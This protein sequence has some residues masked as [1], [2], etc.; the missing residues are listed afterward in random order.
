MSR[1]LGKTQRAILDCLKQS[2][3]PLSAKAIIK[4]ICDNPPPT[5][6]FAVSTN[7]ALKTLEAKRLIRSAHSYGGFMYWLPNQRPYGNGTFET[8][9]PK[10]TGQQVCDAIMF[11][12]RN[13]NKLDFFDTFDKAP[14]GAVSYTQFL[15]K[16]F[17]K[18]K[19]DWYGD[20]SRGRVAILRAIKKLQTEEKIVTYV[21]KK[22]GYYAYIGLSVEK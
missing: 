17:H 11:V 8:I 1:G 13:H 12:L 4:N 9:T 10:V 15:D 7:R 3:E 22:N 16:V 19:M 2:D 18:L 14:P 21:Y 5:R 6:S 20:G